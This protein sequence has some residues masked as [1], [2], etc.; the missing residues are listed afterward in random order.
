M[1]S[2][3]AK[4]KRISGYNKFLKEKSESLKIAISSYKEIL[5]ALLSPLPNNVKEFDFLHSKISTCIHNLELEK[6]N[7]ESDADM[8]NTQLGQYKLQIE[9]ENE[10]NNEE[11]DALENKNFVLTNLIEKQDHVIADL[12]EK[13]KEINEKGLKQTIQTVEKKVLDPAQQALVMHHELQGCRNAFKKLTKGLNAEINKNSRLEHYSKSLREQNDFLI[14]VIKSVYV[15]SDK[16]T[17]NT[18]SL[19]GVD[20]E[21]LKQILS[22]PMSDPMIHEETKIKADTTMNMQKDE[23]INISFANSFDAGNLHNKDSNI[24]MSPIQQDSKNDIANMSASKVKIN[25]PQLDFSKIKKYEEEIKKPVK[26]DIEHIEQPD[27]LLDKNQQINEKILK[28]PEITKNENIVEKPKITEKLNVKYEQIK[29]IEKPQ[30]KEE[31]K[32][33]E[34][35]QIKVVIRK[36]I[37]TPQK[38]MRPISKSTIKNA[39]TSI[40]KKELV[41]PELQHLDD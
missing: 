6:Q 7:L 12:E 36:D 10:K 14:T 9:S 32:K 8:L 1:Y 24:N 31:I 13:I 28:Q 5:F 3:R 27:I 21:A 35:K 39:G 40:K 41:R 17:D 20:I 15:N 18:E 29:I 16:P 37:K 23:D 34:E 33:S 4:A 19:P 2:L 11:I 22:E 30:I 38:Y 26:K 25:I